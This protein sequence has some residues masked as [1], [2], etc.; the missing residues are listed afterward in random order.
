MPKKFRLI[1]LYLLFN[2][3][4]AECKQPRLL[5]PE[6]IKMEFFEVGPLEVL[7][8]MLICGYFGGRLA[9][10]FKFPRVSGYIVAGIL[11][12]PS[13][14]EI[15]PVMLLKEKFIIINDIALAI[16]AFS[17]GASLKFSKLKLL[18]KQIFII[19]LTEALGA[20]LLT[21]A[22]MIVLSPCF[23]KIDKGFGSFVDIY[24]PLA[25]IIAAI[26]AA[27]APAAIIA[28]VHEYKAKGPLTTTLLG[29]VAL[30]DVMAII[31]YAFAGTLIHSLTEANGISFYRAATEPMTIILGSVLLGTIIGYLLSRLS[32]WVKKKESLLVIILGTIFL[33]YGIAKHLQISPILANM[34]LG[35]MIANTAK[36]CD[37]L[38]KALENIE[39]PIF[40]LFFTQAGAHFDSTVIQAAG[41]L[42]ALIVAC[43]FSGKLIGTKFGAAISYA[44]AV[45]KKYLGYGLLPKAGVTLGLVFMA[46]P[47]MMPQLFDV[48]VNAVL[49]SVIINELIAP[50]FVRYALK[51]ANEG[52]KE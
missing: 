10:W 6:K 41:P 36:H 24:F 46:Q 12:S 4:A 1:D 13:V 15:I 45:I 23:V 3:L 16:I 5:C 44:P 51:G 14:F 33:C 27:T 49:G 26:S 52:I 11:L 37:R 38:V 17:V 34:M 20:F 42:A 50:P 40:V 21:F 9:N 30:D 18:S 47:L 29:V 48:M 32:E 22:V 19:N 25:L 35:F 31:L 2:V 43:R 8:V 28:I 7:G 39:E